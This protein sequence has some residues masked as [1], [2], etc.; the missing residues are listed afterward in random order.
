MER[1]VDGVEDVGHERVE[2]RPVDDTALLHRPDG[3]FLANVIL[4]PA[5]VLVCFAICAVAVLLRRSV[6]VPSSNFHRFEF[7]LLFGI[8]HA[9]AQSEARR[10]V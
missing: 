4:L 1:R 9:R 5:V 6:L 3:A 8:E 2:S 10:G 7:A